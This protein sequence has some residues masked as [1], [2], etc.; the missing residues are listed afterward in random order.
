MGPAST[1]EKRPSTPGAAP[2]S[3]QIINPN[4]LRHAPP[5][6]APPAPPPTATVADPK[7]SSRRGPLSPFVLSASQ[8]RKGSPLPRREVRTTAAA[9][10]PP[11]PGQR[12]DSRY[13]NSPLHERSGY[14]S[15]AYNHHTSPAVSAMS[16][17]GIL[18]SQYANSPSR[19]DSPTRSCD[20]EG[21]GD[22]KKGLPKKRR[23][24]DP[25]L[26][27]V[28]SRLMKPTASFLRKTS[29]P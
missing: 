15:S 23:P 2:S 8:P 11:A 24:R 7:R 13:S 6:A 3:Q 12:A 22:D 19:W 9:P 28:E 5:A 18:R 17:S 4:L 1:G 20:S 21:E 29:R 16:A 27:A 14:S 25:K 26:A 10:S